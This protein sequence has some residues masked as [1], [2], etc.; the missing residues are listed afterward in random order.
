MTIIIP[1]GLIVFFL[2]VKD[3]YAYKE[4]KEIES[5]YNNF[6]KP[7]KVRYI[8]ENEQKLDEHEQKIS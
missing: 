6:P 5:R 1:L 7:G 3:Y 4:S 2:S 8:K